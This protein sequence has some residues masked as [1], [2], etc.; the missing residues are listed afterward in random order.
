[1]ARKGLLKW[2]LI[3]FG[4]MILMVAV[5]GYGLYRAFEIPLEAIVVLENR[6]DSPVED[7]RLTY[8][9]EV[10]FRDPSFE[11]VAV[12]AYLRP[13]KEETPIELTFRRADGNEMETYP[14]M[15]RQGEYFEQCAFFISI[16]N[17]EARM[18]GCFLVGFEREARLKPRN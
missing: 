17:E 3:V 1:M 16:L 12:F 7:V 15:A 14:F 4:A 18:R 2:A 5:G 11:S 8:G 13:E 9:G 10:L 6:T